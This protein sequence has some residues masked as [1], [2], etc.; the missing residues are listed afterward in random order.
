MDLNK[1]EKNLTSFSSHVL[2]KMES[3]VK[4]L[5]KT[6]ARFDETMKKKLD[7]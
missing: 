4:E 1:I 7:L 3:D 2:E 5:E 6:S